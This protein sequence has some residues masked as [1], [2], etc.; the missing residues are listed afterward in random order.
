MDFLKFNLQ[1]SILICARCGYCILPTAIQTH[2]KKHHANELSDTDIKAYAK[3]CS[4]YDI[5]SP[6][7]TQQRAVP[8]DTL[9]IPHLQLH[10]NGIRCQLCKTNN[11]FV[12]CSERHMNTHLKNV[13]GWQNTDKG[14]WRKHHQAPLARV[15]ASPIYCQTFYHSNFIRYFQV[16]SPPQALAPA[17]GAGRLRLLRP[18]APESS[19][20]AELNSAA[21]KS[22]KQ[23]LAHRVAEAQQAS[24]VLPA[25][26][27][28]AL[29]LNPWLE[30]T[31]WPKY[32]ASH[33]LGEAMCLIDLPGNITP[34]S[35]QS[36]CCLSAILAAFDRLIEQARESVLAGEINV[37]DQHRVNSFLGRASVNTIF[38]RQC[39][40]RPFLAKLKEGTYQSYKLV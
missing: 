23:Q 39:G 31:Q 25:K 29:Q 3:A 9:L 37:F 30:T 13:H 1:Y 22:I 7:K 6:A 38:R 27:R 28:N 5:A 16:A 26:A 35:S 4:V 36:D 12:C 2:L 34:A 20:N 19:V 14:R 32:L 10:P 21:S 24:L 17:P 40:D 18:K 15:T 8:P 11:P 33:D